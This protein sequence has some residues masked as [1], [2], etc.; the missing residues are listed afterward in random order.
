M[1]DRTRYTPEVKLII[2]IKG[3][4]RKRFFLCSGISKSLQKP[5]RGPTLKETSNICLEWW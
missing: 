3:C 4:P 1:V 5:L 2:I